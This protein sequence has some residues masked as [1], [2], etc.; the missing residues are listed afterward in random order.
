MAD[1]S[2]CPPAPKLTLFFAVLFGISEALAQIPA[3]RANSVFELIL[4]VL[5]ALAG[6]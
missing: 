3:V 6:G 5:K 1:Q 2:Q 4:S